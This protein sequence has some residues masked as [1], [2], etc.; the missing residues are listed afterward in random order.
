MINSIGDDDGD[1]RPFADTLPPRCVDVDD[2]APVAPTTL[3]DARPCDEEPLTDVSVMDI[4]PKTPPDIIE[5]GIV[6]YC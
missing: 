5:S 4:L 2:D 3:D 1:S 6:M